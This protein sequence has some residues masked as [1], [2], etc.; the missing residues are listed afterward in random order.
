VKKAALLLSIAF[1]LFVA[2]GLILYLKYSQRDTISVWR[3]IP[4]QAVLVYESGDCKSCFAQLQENPVWVSIDEILIKRKA[5]NFQ[6]VILKDIVSNLNWLASLH[7][8][9]RNNFDFVFYSANNADFIKK[10]GRWIESGNPVLTKR[11]YSGFVIH[12]LKQKDQVFSWTIIEDFWIGSFTYFLIEDV[13]RTYNSERRMESTKKLPLVKNDLG[14]MYIRYD[15]LNTLLNSFLQDGA[16]VKMEVAHSA[17]FDIKE[18]PAVNLSGFSITGKPGDVTLLACFAGQNPV[19]FSHKRFISNR[20]LVV[21]NYGIDKGEVFFNNLPIAK[22]YNVQDSLNALAAIDIKA[23]FSELGKEISVCLLE[24]RK[25]ELTKVVLFDVAEKK[26]WTRVFDLLS[27][28]TESGDSLYTEMY[29]PYKLRKIDLKNLPEK[30][31]RPLISGFEQTY[32]TILEN[33]FILSEHPADMKR[34]LDDIDNEEVWGKAVSTNQFLESTLLESN[35][36]IHFN[37]QLLKNALTQRLAP[38]WKTYFA[39]NKTILDRLGTGAIQFSNLNEMFYTH[40]ILTPGKPGLT[41]GSRVSQQRVQSVIRSAI[42]SSLFSVRNHTTKRNDLVF[43]DSLGL[44]YYFSSDEKLQW[45]LPLNGAITGEMKQIDYF[46]NGKL[47]LFFVTPGKLHVVDRLGNYVSPFPVAIP[48]I[49]PEFANVIDYD[50]SK[51][52]RFIL[53]DQSGRIWM[54]DKQGQPLDGW[55]PKLVEGRPIAPP[56]HYRIQGKDYLIVFRQDGQVYLMNRKGELVKGFPLVL[57]VRPA[58]SFYFEPDKSLASSVFTCISKD[59]I[60]IR[61][62]AEGKVLSREP[63]VKSTINDQFR[64]IEEMSGNGYLIARQNAK[65]LTIFDDGHEIVSN[66]YVG[67]SRV[68]VHYY[69]FGSGRVFI[70]VTDHDQDLCYLYDGK[71]NALIATPID[72]NSAV[73]MWDSTL[74]LFYADGK[75]LTMETF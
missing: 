57:D 20:A 28:A 66:E 5:G 43:Q 40:F 53:S 38:V 46:N 47:Q 74:K 9:Q 22:D 8:T 6:E 17:I 51:R 68:D 60:K 54:Y 39:E 29:G 65:Q 30:L 32:Y 14:N 4:E 31:F 16:F 26:T 23:S 41:N 52:Y 37:V 62:T 18:G 1:M 55:R 15:G 11:E 70:V 45:T 71:G 58:G 56:R 67:N 7:L 3:I 25:S 33:T 2:A 73:L 49:Q 21:S 36:S 19:A 44:L 24:R 63:L 42:H 34:F 61:F 27:K 10:A 50:N 64:L 12:E 69:D 59:G 13:I 35:V 48:V 75:M 72:A